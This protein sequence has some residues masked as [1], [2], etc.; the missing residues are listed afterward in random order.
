[1]ADQTEPLVSI[2]VPVFNG[3][4]TLRR[5][6]DALLAQ[7]YPNLE[8]IISDN[9]STDGTGAIAAEYAARDKRVKYFRAE[10]N[11]GAIWNFNRV[12]ALA[13]G[14][15]FM[16]AASDDQRDH[17]FVRACVEKLEAC[18]NAVLCQSHTAMLIEGKQEQ[19][20]LATLDTFE[21]K[22]DTPTRYRETLYHFPAT[23]MY[24]L[25][26][27]SAMKKTKMF[28]KSIA[29]DIAL[30]QELSIYGDFVQVPAVLFHYI[31]REHWNT[32]EQDY[33]V[34]LGKD[35]KPWW[36]V[37]FFVLFWNHLSRVLSA[38]VGVAAK[39]RL[40]AILLKYEIRQIG[41]KLAVKAG[42][43]VGSERWKRRIGPR[44]YRRWML[45]PN[46]QIGDETLFLERVVKPTLGWWR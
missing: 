46:V 3:E 31:G 10:K 38:D 44:L 25:V 16:W 19:L 43:R 37:P 6:L 40:S 42:S 30:M 45:S 8:I 22:Q 7:D 9:A 35:G 41:L 13:S 39:L 23:G 26:R 11:S 4:K 24:G 20:A 15:Y 28:R 29:T 27:S 12:F 5:A 32:V 21:G 33:K 18:P 34:Y 14:K 1:M 2:G 17:S 36:Y